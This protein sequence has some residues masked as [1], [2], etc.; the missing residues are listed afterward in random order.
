LSYT[1]LPGHLHR[2]DVKMKHFKSLLIPAA[3]ALEK[4]LFDKNTQLAHELRKAAE[5]TT[6]ES[7]R[8][9]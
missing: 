1:G 6:E 3:D 8:W 5:S 9:M 2:L 7:E 4:R